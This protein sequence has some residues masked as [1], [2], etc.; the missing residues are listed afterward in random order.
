MSYIF[1]FISCILVIYLLVKYIQNKNIDNDDIKINKD[2][3][4]IQL[5]SFYNQNIDEDLQL[6]V[7]KIEEDDVTDKVQEKIEKVYQLQTHKIKYK[8][9]DTKFKLDFYLNNLYQNVVVENLYIDEPFHTDFYKLLL[10]LNKD[11]LMIV[12]KKAKVLTLNIRDTN[13]QMQ[14]SKSYSVF[15]VKDI[16]VEVLNISLNKILQFQKSDAQNIILAICILSIQKSQHFETQQNQNDRIQNMLDID[17]KR[18]EFIINLIN[19]K[20]EQ[21]LFIDD[22]INYAFETTRTYPYND[23]EK[24]Q[25]LSLDIKLPKKVLM[26]I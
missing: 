16:I 17:F 14:I 25:V 6:K 24:Q 9:Y 11:E 1:I 13:N 15:S 5:S 22:A 7:K 23:S 12:D 21:L 8:L 26:S 18:I 2:D 10:L 20:D 4:Y 3:N 19:K